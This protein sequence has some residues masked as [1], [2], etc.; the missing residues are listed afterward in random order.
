MCR[1]SSGRQ[2]ESLVQGDRPGGTRLQVKCY[3]WYVRWPRPPMHN[4]SMSRNGEPPSPGER[5][6]DRRPPA[7]LVVLFPRPG[8]RNPRP[9]GNLAG[10]PSLTTF[11]HSKTP[12]LQ[13]YDGS[14]SL[15]SRIL[16]NHNFVC[17]TGRTVHRSREASPFR[18]SFTLQPYHPSLN[19]IL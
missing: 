15:A 1:Q 5:P 13:R 18:R 11:L 3:M 10:K 6:D 9:G 2:S 17:E 4:T 7:L 14:G 12:A 8:H 16:R 19:P